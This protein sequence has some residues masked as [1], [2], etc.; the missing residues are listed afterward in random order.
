MTFCGSLLYA[1]PEIYQSREYSTAVDQWSLGVVVLE[2]SYGHL[3]SGHPQPLVWRKE[4]KQVSLMGS[5]LKTDDPTPNLQTNRLHGTRGVEK[6]PTIIFG[7]LWQRES[8]PPKEDEIP[9]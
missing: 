5:F 3:S 1:A 7:Q 8:F 4:Q 2:Y 6:A 9:S